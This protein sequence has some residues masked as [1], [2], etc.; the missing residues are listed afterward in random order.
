[1]STI[2]VAIVQA[3]VAFMNLSASVKRAV[4]L[5]DKAAS[6]GARLIVF[7]ETWLPGYPAWLDYCPNAALW[8]HGPTKEIYAAIPGG[9]D[10]I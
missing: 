3:E 7:G 5:I 2:K 10:C 9:T 6:Q 4:D 8:D 1:L